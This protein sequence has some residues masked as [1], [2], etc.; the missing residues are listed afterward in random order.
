MK[1]FVCRATGCRKIRCSYMA[2]NLLHDEEGLAR[3]CWQV[4]GGRVSQ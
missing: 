2:C 3:S 1:D 4:R